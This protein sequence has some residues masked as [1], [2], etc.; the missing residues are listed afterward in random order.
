MKCCEDEA[1]WGPVIDSDMIMAQLHGRDYGAM[2]KWKFCPWC[3]KKVEEE[4]R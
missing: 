2:P 4:E 1:K 3:G